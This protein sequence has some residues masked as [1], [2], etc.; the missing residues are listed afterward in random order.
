LEVDTAGDGRWAHLRDVVVPA[1]SSSFVQFSPKEFGTW[2]RLTPDRAAR[3]VTAF[4]HY[5]V[6]DQ[7]SNRASRIFAGIATPS[8]RE[9]STGL[10]H[11]GAGKDSALRLL[12]GPSTGGRSEFYELNGKMQL[13]KV[14]DAS[15]AAAMRTNAA[16]P[17]TL[18][19][20]DAASAY[21]LDPQGRRWRLPKGA[22][23]F[24]A[25]DVLREDRACREV[26]TERNLLNV[27]GSFYEMPAEN[28]G[29]FYKIRPI[30]THN[31]R[32]SDYASYRGLLVLSG[33]KR[34]AR[35]EHIVRSEDARH[36][37]WVGSVDDLWKLGKPRGAGGP[38]LNSVVSAHQASDPYLMTGY[39][40]KTVTL[41]HT[42][43]SPVKMR[44]EAD[45]AGTGDWVTYAEFTVAPRHPLKHRFPDGF[46]AY[47]VRVVA[48]REVVASAQFLYE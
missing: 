7:R 12:A 39:D 27:H 21:Y 41:S 14:D 33:V 8:D 5:R 28:A 31:L 46:G 42:G 20:A 30:A 37:L 2:V 35:G 13:V 45:V 11:V 34:T 40:R 1:N 47:W 26:C 3:R 44:I 29:G 18:L 10:L 16:I 24:D 48:D 19:G 23:A 25:P 38:W 36:A 4:F 6:K 15:R 43:Q 17:N 32:V 22:P 9:T